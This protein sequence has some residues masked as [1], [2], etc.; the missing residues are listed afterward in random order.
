MREGPIGEAEVDVE[1]AAAAVPVLGG[2]GGE[3]CLSRRQPQLLEQLHRHLVRLHAR[4]LSRGRVRP[5]TRD[6]AVVLCTP[7]AALMP[8]RIAAHSTSPS[9]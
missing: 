1:L 4:H 3:L 9:E 2:G 8:D 6:G 7:C 5:D